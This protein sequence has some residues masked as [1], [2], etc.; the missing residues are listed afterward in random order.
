MSCNKN[1]D[2]KAMVKVVYTD[3]TPVNAAAVKLY[4]TVKT[5]SPPQTFTAD[6]KAT[7]TTDAAGTVQ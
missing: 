6:I 1:T 2:C 7:G 4:A 3:G 5:G